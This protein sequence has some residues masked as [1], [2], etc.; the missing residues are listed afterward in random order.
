M[1]TLSEGAGQ[2]LGRPITEVEERRFRQYV[3]LLVKWQKSHRLIGSSERSWIVENIILDSMLFLRV[4][5]D[6]GVQIGGSLLDLG[7]G[8]GIPGLPI[9]IVTDEVE[10]TLLEARSRRAAFLSAVVREI[11]LTGTAVVNARAEDVLDELGGM[12][13]T[14]VMRCAGRLGLVLPLAVEF[15]RPGGLVVAS[16]RS[17]AAVGA[18]PFSTGGRGLACGLSRGSASYDVRWREVPGLGLGRTRCFAVCRKG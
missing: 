10:V 14:V 5:V 8:A 9:K 2:I 11:G 17:G 6:E 15:L 18:G 3:E 13:S 12:F 1:E 7:A 16:G 4:L